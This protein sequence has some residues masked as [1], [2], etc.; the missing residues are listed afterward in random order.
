MYNI[1]TKLK[2]IISFCTPT[3]AVL[4]I[5]LL[6]FTVGVKIPIHTQNNIVP[7]TKFNIPFLFLY[8]VFSIFIFFLVL[9]YEKDVVGT[10][11]NNKFYHNAYN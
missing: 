10:K 5:I 7:H 1:H 6:L 8:F 2:I 4:I 9:V 11:S 3:T